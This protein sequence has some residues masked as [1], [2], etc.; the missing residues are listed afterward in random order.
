MTK[1]GLYDFSFYDLINRN[2]RLYAGLP[3]WFEID[4][5]RALSFEEYKASVDRLAQGLLVAGVSK[6]D[7]IGILGKNSLEY[8]LL[9]GAAAALGAIVLPINCRVGFDCF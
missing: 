6:G 2:A 9:Y 8:F 7:R 1:L 3:A 5:D 4:D